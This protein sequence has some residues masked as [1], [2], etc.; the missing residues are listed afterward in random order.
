MKLPLVQTNARFFR[1]LGVLAAAQ[2]VY[3]RKYT[4]KPAP[5]SNEA[6]IRI[7]F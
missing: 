6:T 2:E 5:S 4:A 7:L 3:L 1:K